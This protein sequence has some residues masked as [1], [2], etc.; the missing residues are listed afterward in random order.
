MS[1]PVPVYVCTDK[2]DGTEGKVLD[3]LCMLYSVCTAR[4]GH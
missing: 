2:F 3:R 4:Y 1:V